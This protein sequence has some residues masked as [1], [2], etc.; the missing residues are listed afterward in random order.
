M[1]KLYYAFLFLVVGMTSCNDWLDITP[2]DTVVEEQLFATGDGYRNVLNGV[3]KQMATSSMYGRELTYGMLDAM[4]QLYLARGFNSASLYANAM[5]YNYEHQDVE[6]AIE[7]IWSTTY[8]A[9]ANCN[10]ILAKIDDTDS[11]MFRSL[12]NEKML[13]KG[14]ALALRAFLHFDMMRLFAPNPQSGDEQKYIPY[15]KVY[16]STF[17]PDRTTKEVLEFVIQ[18]L[19]EARSLV[20]P[21]DT[22]AWRNMLHFNSRFEN[23]GGDVLQNPDLFFRHRGYRM[24][25]LAICSMLARAYNYYGVFD[26]TYYQKAYDI[27]EHVM[28]F[29]IEGEY[30][31][32]VDFTAY[33]YIEDDPKAHEEVIFCLSNQKLREDYEAL[34]SGTR[35]ESFYLRSDLFDDAADVRQEYLT[36]PRGSYRVCIKNEE[37]SSESQYEFEDMIPLFRLGELY[38]IQAEV[39]ARRGD[40]TA[41]VDKIDVVRGERNCQIGPMGL[42]AQQIRD[43]NTFK[44]EMVMEATREF[45]QEGQAFF[46]YKRFNILPSSEAT[47]ADF[48]LPKPDSEVLY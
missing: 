33:Y 48:V 34:Q 44:E 37:L 45:M 32:C 31:P 26:D 5:S 15:Y 7:S 40:I 20:A 28:G 6:S 18:D 41:A 14:E 8:N 21:Q 27:A 35:G 2:K 16:P 47:E 42:P 22:I 4:G 25:Y 24:N 9:I 19:E 3:Y 29:S 13:I 39:L 23:N 36:E 38:F 10:S 30:Y 11:T 12:N 46:Y 43:W 17:E 1:R